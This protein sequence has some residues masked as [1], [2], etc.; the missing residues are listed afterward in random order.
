MS[1]VC[2]DPVAIKA[3]IAAGEDAV[4]DALG[5][6]MQLPSHSKEDSPFFDAGLVANGME[7]YI[8]SMHDAQQPQ[9]SAFKPRSAGM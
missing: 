3:G 9:Q 6:K 7:P 4:R 5:Q 2:I 8:P 1:P